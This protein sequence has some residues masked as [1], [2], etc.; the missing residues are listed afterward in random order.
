M[1]KFEEVFGAALAAIEQQEAYEAAGRQF[2][3]QL[4]TAFRD[5]LGV[6][7][8]QLQVLPPASQKGG[9]VSVSPEAIELG[10]DAYFRTRIKLAHNRASITVSVRFKMSGEGCW[11]VSFYPDGRNSQ[12]VS[13]KVPGDFKDLIET[14]ASSIEEVLRGN[15]EAFL[16]G[17]SKRMGFSIDA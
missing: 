13:P 7:P 17:G 16:G 4:V 15:F 3:T 2:A 10:D 1:G 5:T 6:P 9:N 8:G 12:R 11:E 14:W